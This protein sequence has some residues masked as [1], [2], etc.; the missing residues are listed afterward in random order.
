MKNIKYYAGLLDSD[1]SIQL[2]PYKTK[3]GFIIR[4]LVCFSQKTENDWIFN[5]LSKEYSIDISRLERLDK[6]TGKI[7]LESK[8]NLSSNKAIRFLEQI[9]KYLVIKDKLA[10]FALRFDKKMVNGNEL[11]SIRS[12]FK[13]LRDDK[14]PSLK[15]FPTRQW[16]A[17]Y[18]DG[19]G[20]IGSSYRKRDGN[21]EFKCTI[22]S[23][24]ND[25]QG[26]YLINRIFKGYIITTDNTLRIILPLNKTSAEKFITY[27]NT[28]LRLKKQ[29]FDYVLGILRKGSHLKKNGATKESNWI[30]Y[31]TLKQLKRQQ[32]LNEYSS[33]DEV[34]V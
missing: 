25:P 22:T 27:F 24:I 15:N 31:N 32:R 34:I 16:L 26:I 18:I 17:G 6:R 29:Q 7:Y 11:K 3:D 10:E 8:L 4:F 12:V 19:D 23:H 28:H 5:E 20:C 30:I 2:A 33:L 21:I 13:S 14:E 9:K 1:G